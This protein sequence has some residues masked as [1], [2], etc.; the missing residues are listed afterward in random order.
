LR[1]L[2]VFHYTFS[3]IED[4]LFLRFTSSSLSNI[5][6]FLLQVLTKKSKLQ[7]EMLNRE[8]EDDI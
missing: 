6:L 4:I 1:L 2:S 5:F 8:M 7:K 3:I